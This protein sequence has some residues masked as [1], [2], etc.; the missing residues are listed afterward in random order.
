MNPNALSIFSGTARQSVRVGAILLLS[1]IGTGVTYAQQESQADRAMRKAQGMLRQLASEKNALE[2]KIGELES[3]LASA[4]AEAFRVQQ[5]VNQQQSINSAMMGNNAALVERIKSDQG[6][7]QNIIEKYRARQTEL[8]LYQHDHVLLKN[9]II[10]RDEWISSCQK[11]NALLIDAGKDLLIRYNQKSIWDS[12]VALE[13]ISGI[14]NVD[15]EVENQEYRFKLEDLKIR[16]LE[17]GAAPLNIKQV[18]VL[19]QPKVSTEQP[20]K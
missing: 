9:I 18:E 4:K 7:I 2:V 1:V 11:A 15:A 8:E 3:E 6:K 20:L 17:A 14:G 10:E 5:E 16:P 13:P 19:S 12:I